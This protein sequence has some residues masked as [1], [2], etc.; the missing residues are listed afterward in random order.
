M[1]MM[2]LMP[3]V[4]LMLI[5]ISHQTKMNCLIV[6]LMTLML[7]VILGQS[8]VICLMTILIIL[9]LL[10]TRDH[11]I[12]KWFDDF[13]ASFNMNQEKAP[14]ADDDFDAFRDFSCS[15]RFQLRAE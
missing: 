12:V 4:T 10:L 13:D 5:V 6:I 1:L 15:S 3:L 2:T 9:A 11:S 8:R 14:Y 7:T